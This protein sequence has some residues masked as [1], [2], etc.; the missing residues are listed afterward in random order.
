[1]TI[2]D[3]PGSR[4]SATT[5]R[6]VLRRL[7][8]EATAAPPARPTAPPMLLAAATGE[9]KQDWIAV[10]EWRLAQHPTTGDLVAID[11]DGN[12][13]VLFSRGGL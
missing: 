3:A 4:S 12:D 5:G 2:K 13:R 7:Q 10:G 1:M 9:P 11:P 8:R 6:D